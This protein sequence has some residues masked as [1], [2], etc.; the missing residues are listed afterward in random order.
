METSTIKT[1]IN[2]P[3]VPMAVVLDGVSEHGE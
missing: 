1:A 2:N 3:V